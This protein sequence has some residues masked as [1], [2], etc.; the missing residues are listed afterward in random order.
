MT[1]FDAGRRAASASVS[2]LLLL[3]ALSA[4]QPAILRSS[5]RLPDPQVIAACLCDEGR[6][7]QVLASGGESLAPYRP[8]VA[9][10]TLLRG[11][12]GKLCLAADGKLFALSIQDGRVTAAPFGVVPRAVR[13]IRHVEGSRYVLL[14]GGAVTAHGL[15]GCDLLLADIHNGSAHRSDQVGPQQHPQFVETGTL[16]GVAVVLVGVRTR[17]VF[18]DRLRLRPWIFAV[19]GTG[20]RPVWLG[21][22]FS[23]PFRGAAFCDCVKDEGEEICAVEL[24]REGDR[25][26]IAYRK[27]GLVVE[28]VAR[29]AAGAFGSQLRS[30]PQRAQ[31]GELLCIWAGGCTG[32]ILGMRAAAAPGREVVLLL[33]VVQTDYIKRPLAWD[34]GWKDGRP[35]AFVLQA[36]KDFH[37]RALKRYNGSYER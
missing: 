8:P 26:I 25:Q 29:S 37:S 34:V 30:L 11:P 17:A 5:H 12:D 6:Q 15:R 19:D 21:T 22:S 24:T 9:A 7:I 33:P 10:D 27:R 36:G 31:A 13:A 23:R 14:S 28:A 18:D 4:T 32:R 16:G 35:A 1:R 20:L 2:A 3:M